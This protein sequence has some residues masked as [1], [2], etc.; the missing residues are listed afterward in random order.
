MDR[1]R[2]GVIGAGMIGMAHL[3]ALRRLPE[4]EIVA[5]C[6]RDCE[7]ARA[8]AG[9]YGIPWAGD[10]YRVMLARGD[11]DAV[12]N[13]TPTLLHD[14]INRAIIAAGKHVYAEKP[15]ARTAAE[16]YETWQRAERSGIVHGIN[17]QY[18]LYA[19]AQ[20]MRARIAGGQMGRAFLAH[21]HYMQQSSLYPEEYR[22]RMT[23]EGMRCALSDIG[24]HWV[25]LA[26]C[27]LGRRVERVFA[28]IRTLHPV[29]T[30][31]DGQ[32]IQVETDDMSTLLLT[33]EG[34]VQ[35]MLA[36]SKA[37]A[38][39]M[40]DLAIE[41]QGQACSL[42]WAQ[43]DPARL[44]IGRKRG[45][46]EVLRVAPAL[47]DDSVADLVTLPGGHVQGWNDALLASV[48][49]FYAAVRG[50]A[51]RCATFA[52]GFEAMAF[53]EAALESHEKGTWARVRRPG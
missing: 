19:A 12:H 14:G 46:D 51:A 45:L 43:E 52:D 47:V 29:R 30:L 35:G 32:E 25:D 44:R 24:T 50:E 23:D 40:N 6:T 41:V 2:V 13:C 33:F 1:I 17:Y 38:G 39:H 9:R 49:A 22:A 4:V 20:E 53:V 42:A 7:R 48:R 34:G 31:P 8:V 5:L 10:D 36:V 21:G 3:D 26:C 37:S 27:V 28:D 16:A 18:R 15:L 11:I